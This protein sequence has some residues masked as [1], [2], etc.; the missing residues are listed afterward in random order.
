MKSYN[1]HSVNILIVGGGI[2]GLTAALA[3]KGR[4]RVTLVEKAG[5]CGGLLRSW[6]APKGLAFDYGT[7]VLGE[8]GTKEVDDLLFGRLD[9]KAWKRFKIVRSAAYFSGK[10]YRKSP[11]L[12][13]RALP[14]A[15]YE[16]A[17]AELQ[18]AP[19]SAGAPA[20]FEEQVLRVHGRTI[21]EKVH[22]PAMRKI[23]GSELKDLLPDHSFELKRFV[24]FDAD[25]ARAL[26]KDPRL[27]AKIGFTT[28][29]E[30]VPS[31]DSLY[32]RSGGVG[33]WVAGLCE[34]LRAGGVELLTGRA[35]SRLELEG[36]RPKAAV[37][38]DGRRLDCDRVLWTVSPQL[39]LGALG[40]P[41]EAAPVPMRPMHFFHFAFDRPFLADNYY[42][43]N[44]DEDFRSFR[45]TLYPNL[46]DAAPEGGWH[47]TVEV[48]GDA[49]P[50][51]APAIRAEL[52]RM[53]LT[54]PAA[55]LTYS[56]HKMTPAGFPVLDR[57]FV[58]SANRQVAAAR[59][60]APGVDAVGR[61]KNGG[62]AMQDVAVE[63]YRRARA[64][65]EDAAVARPAA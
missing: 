9:P 62:F 54:D 23:L 18:A 57:A 50:G 11:H 32:P 10:L 22:R 53:G 19:A 6:S 24:C 16:K 12:D 25:R 20:T 49:A 37:L 35:V 63:A 7:H 44:Y 26:K 42:V 52:D 39:L 13:L 61:A 2:A 64:L 59:A 17:V 21:T 56:D 60:A 4:A 41:R 29:E 30:G 58:E 38:D 3:L 40:L 31:V 46:Q 45:I 14:R 33:Q 5:E 47:C 55:V 1:V 27:D 8:S 34:E 28:W 48:V 43:S 65:L 51:D 15:D 36:G